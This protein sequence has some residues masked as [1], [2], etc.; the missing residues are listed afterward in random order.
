MKINKVMKIEDPCC[1][2]MERALIDGFI[3]ITTEAISDTATGP[4]SVYG[5]LNTT[6]S[7]NVIG[8][9]LYVGTNGLTFTST[10]PNKKVGKFVSATTVNL[11]DPT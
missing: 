4:V 7:G 5:G 2:H 10:A 9:V 11:V 3:G 6:F 1:E 8:S